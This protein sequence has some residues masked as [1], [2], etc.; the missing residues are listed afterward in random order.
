MLFLIQILHMLNKEQINHF[1]DMFSDLT[2]ELEDMGY[3][4]CPEQLVNQ[5]LS[6]HFDMDFDTTDKTA[7]W[8]LEEL[9]K[10]VLDITKLK[11]A[12]TTV[13]AQKGLI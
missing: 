5:L 3:K 4:D 10:T 9:T 13:R 8:Q 1:E 2:F 7:N 12:L 11:P 6:D